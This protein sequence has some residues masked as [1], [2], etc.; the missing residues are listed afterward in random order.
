MKPSSLYTESVRFRV[1][2]WLTLGSQSPI[3]H[4]EREVHVGLGDAHRRLDPEDV[5]LEP[6]LADEYPCLTSRLE[7]VERL[8]LRRLLRGAVAHQLDAQHE[9]HAAHVTDQ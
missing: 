3:E 4:V 6:T 5:A 7:H 8:A 2:P 9:T 1:H